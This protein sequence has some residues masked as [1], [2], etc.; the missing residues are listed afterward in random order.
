[1]SFA[2]LIIDDVT[3]GRFHPKNAHHHDALRTV[4]SILSTPTSPENA[5]EHADKF[6][7]DRDLYITGRELHDTKA[8]PM[9]QI[10][11]IAFL[12]S[13]VTWLEWPSIIKNERC[14]NG[15]LFVQDDQGTD[16]LFIASVGKVWAMLFTGKL[17]E[18]LPYK[19]HDPEGMKWLIGTSIF[20]IDEAADEWSSHLTEALYG[21]LL[22]TVPRAVE[23]RPHVP[24]P[25]LQ[26]SRVRARKPPL[27]E[28][29][30]VKLNIGNPR[31][32]YERPSDAACAEAQGKRALHRVCAH[33]RTYT[34]GREQPKVAFIPSHF[35]GDPS[36]GLVIH[37]REVL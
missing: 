31:I 29:R 19:V 10:H 15:M 24:S 23:L 21:L 17:M 6:I 28:C 32:R 1:M 35:R 37:E 27:V 4:A 14:K 25:A 36:L 9:D 12:P 22:L 20:P 26:R 18:N 34:K 7:F 3:A 5:Q 33:L 13:P 11:K 30:H 8:V 2:Q 16:L